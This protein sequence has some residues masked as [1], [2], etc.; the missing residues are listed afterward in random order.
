[1]EHRSGLSVD[2]IVTQADG[3]GE[4]DAALLMVD[5]VRGDHRISVAADKSP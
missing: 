3:Y 4:R 2:A 5:P 1:M